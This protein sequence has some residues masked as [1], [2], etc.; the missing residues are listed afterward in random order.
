[1]KI[2]GKCH[3]G[4][5]TYEVDVDPDEVYVCHCTD[6]QAI[7][8]SAFRWAVPVGEAAFKLLSGK[9]KTYVKTTESGATSHQLFRPE[10][11]SPLYST[12]IAVGPKVPNLRLGTDVSA[13]S[14][15]QKRNTGVALH[16]TGPQSRSRP[17]EL[18]H[19]RAPRPVPIG[20]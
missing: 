17:G 10:C 9:P 5:I 7:S 1:M 19:N 15:G 16:R 18:T 11:A 20:N 3:C 2:Q 14:C 12:S 6:C 13:P 4:P 8:G